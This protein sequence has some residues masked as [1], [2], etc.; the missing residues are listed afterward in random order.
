[1]PRVRTLAIALLAGALIVTVPVR[2]VRLKRYFGKNIA[3][4][5]MAS[6]R[7][8]QAD[9]LFAAIRA[10]DAGGAPPLFVDDSLK[11]RLYVA[12]MGGALAINHARLKSCA[13]DR[14]SLNFLVTEPLASTRH[15]AGTRLGVVEDVQIVSVVGSPCEPAAAGH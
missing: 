6:G 10:V 3:T 4:A 8:G 12:T 1:M 5:W 14:A 7:R 15:V 2:L 9:V 11:W 13:G